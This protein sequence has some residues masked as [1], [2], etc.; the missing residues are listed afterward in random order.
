MLLLLTVLLAVL[1]LTFRAGL[2]VL[3][4][5]VLRRAVRS[6][7]LVLLLSI[8]RGW[9][10]AVALVLLRICAVAAALPLWGVPAL[11]TVALLLIV[12]LLVIP[13]LAV[14]AALVVAVVARH[15]DVALGIV[16]GWWNWV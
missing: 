14:V 6:L 3:V 8:G 13:L 4:A 12:A 9:W 2:T 1:L 5:T 7:L 11:L 10:S 15:F 16:M